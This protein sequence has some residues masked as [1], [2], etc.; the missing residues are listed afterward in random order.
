MRILL[1][2]P[3][4]I[5][6]AV[7]VGEMMFSEP[8]GL[9]MLYGILK[10]DHH[11]RIFDMMIDKDLKS[12]LE[13]YNPQAVGF[14]SLCVDVGMVLKL[15]RLVKDLDPTI[16]TIVGGTQ[17]LLRPESFYD[18]TMD[19]IFKFTTENNLKSLLKMLEARALDIIP[20]VLSRELSYKDE[21]TKG[22][23]QYLIPDRSSTER[24]RRSYSYFGYMPA[25]IMEYGTG[26]GKACRFCLRWGI[27]GVEEKLIDPELTKRDLLSIEEDTIMFIDND[28]F[29][30][31]DKIR[32]FLELVKELGLRK[33]YIV[34]GSV[35]GILGCKELLPEFVD[36]GLKAV[37]VGYET[38]S[39]TELK[40][41]RKRATA[42]DSEEVSRLLKAYKVDV[43][44]SFMAHPDWE[45]RDFKALRR[46]INLLSPEISTI[47]PLT[48]FPGLPIYKEF[49]D[50]LLFPEDDQERWSFGQVV[51]MPSQM[52]LRS[53]YWEL[54]KTYL[55]INLMSNKSTE[56]LKKY[57]LKSLFRI[58]M[59]SARLSIKYL[60]LILK[61]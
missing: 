59:G 43:W 33:N 57:G 52:S 49:K 56:M 5:K 21:G 13:E 34:Y 19:H 48:P 1:V 31:M 51:V 3:P 12:E 4:R 22:R 38:F 39:D 8:L 10:P 30:S 53:Y 9:E 41:Y 16:T 23:N 29:S 26:C 17:C 37:L 27:E 46:F 40:E 6:Q 20:G 28:F 45:K 36:I 11:V 61:Q 50:R 24:Y 60:N 47:N 58:G 14:T 32:G 42:T 15:S 54:M 25:A 7:T 2:R 18:E 35:E 44:A 55:Y